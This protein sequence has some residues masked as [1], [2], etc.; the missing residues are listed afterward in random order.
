MHFYHIQELCKVSDSIDSDER[1]LVASHGAFLACFLEYL[2]Q[3]KDKFVLENVDVKKA[4]EPA[5]TTG[6][7]QIRIGK[8]DEQGIRTLSFLELHDQKHLEGVS[9]PE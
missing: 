3:S 5:P 8:P 4:R 7:T 9:L 1:V 6:V 2:I